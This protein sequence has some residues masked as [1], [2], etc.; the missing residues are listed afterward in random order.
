MK[1]LIFSI[2]FLN[3][4]FCVNSFAQDETPEEEL[5]PWQVSEV[6]FSFLK[7]RSYEPAQLTNVIA[8]ASG[9]DL[10]INTVITDM[11]TLKKFY[12]DNGFFNAIVDTALS[13]NQE[14]NEVVI[15]YTII[16]NERSRYNQIEYAG[17]DSLAPNLQDT[18]FSPNRDQVQKFLLPGEFY[19]RA[20]INLEIGRI[21]RILQNNGYA[22]AKK[23][24]VKVTNIFSANP[25]LQNK[26]D[27]ELNFNTGKFSR[28]GKTT[29]DISG[30]RYGIT[31]EYIRR[32]LEY[33]EGQVF[34]QRKLEASNS[35][36]LSNAIIESSTFN[37]DS[38]S[39][40]INGTV[41]LDL[42]ISIRNKYELTP[43]V[44]AYEIDNRFYG[45]LGLSF[46]DRFF[47]KGSRVLNASV[48]GLAHN[49]KFN[50]L[51]NSVQVSE[52]YLFG[53]PNLAGNIRLGLNFLNIDSISAIEISGKASVSYDLPTFTY[54]NKLIFFSE[55]LNQDIRLDGTTT[56][57]NGVPS[58]VRVKINYFAS[59]IGASAQHLGIDNPVFPTKGFNQTLSVQE[60]GLLG[61]LLE[62]IFDINVFKFIKS[63][64][65]NKVF[66]NFSDNL[67]SR[68]VLGIKFNVGVIFET[69]DNNERIDST[70]KLFNINLPGSPIDLKFTAGGGINNRGWRANTLGFVP[71]QE[72]GGNFSIDGMFEHRLRPFINSSNT[73]IKDLGFVYFLDYGNVWENVGDFKLDQIAISTGFGVR[74]FTI[75]G[76]IRLDLGLKLY[77][78]NP[79]HVG[80]T[81]WI[82]QPGANLNDKYT[83]QFGIGNTF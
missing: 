11:I 71:D 19:S 38:T 67:K 52:S 10:N 48:R 22:F 26:V 18:I 74:Y 31:T 64:V 5:E 50:R 47:L 20:Q 4:L 57:P 16:E 41:D 17:L 80:V 59:S 46:Y 37:L 79:G 45:G 6:K 12:F 40:D 58:T 30:N 73:L 82:F 7:T 44:L 23:E 1:L 2:F 63:T 9:T 75:I 69:G 27:I 8:A 72:E 34:D 39:D 32:N 3:L 42:K 51:E 35:R 62:N 76:A 55:A 29:I 36:I 68:S 78:P 25:N 24:E 28:F 14:D 33:N 49:F 60:G 77:D 13:Y 70:E 56:D 61:Q 54:I 15:T 53:N 65:S 66:F 83:I 43:E 21:L 81:N